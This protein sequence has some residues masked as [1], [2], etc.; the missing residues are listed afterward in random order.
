MNQYADTAKTF[1][2]L[3]ILPDHALSAYMDMQANRLSEQSEGRNM[4]T[5]NGRYITALFTQ[6]EKAF[7][8]A[9]SAGYE[10]AQRLSDL[11]CDLEFTGNP[12]GTRNLTGI[13]FATGIPGIAFKAGFNQ[14]IVDMA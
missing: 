12:T 6:D 2:S 1:R 10:Q 5:P 8:D 4:E 3:A 14:W 9:Y 13:R 7:T 11:E